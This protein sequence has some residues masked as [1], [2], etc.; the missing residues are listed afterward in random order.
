MNSD[1]HIT[2]RELK[3]LVK[4]MFKLVK[5]SIGSEEDGISLPMYM[6]EP[7]SLLQRSGEMAENWKT[8]VEANL[9]DDPLLRMVKLS[10]F[11]IAQFSSTLNRTTKPFVPI[12]GETC[13]WKDKEYTY[14]MEC[15]SVDPQ[16]KCNCKN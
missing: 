12:L 2:E 4:D 15:V 7:L 1:G 6:Y 14:L 11:S 9:E 10:A 3:R 13:E 16:W 5:D 8:L